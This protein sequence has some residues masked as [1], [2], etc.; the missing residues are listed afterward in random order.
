MT[1]AANCLSDV[2]G[3]IVV[4]K[5]EAEIALVELPIAGLMSDECAE[6][7]I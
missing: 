6:V 1:L 2:G 5:D 7:I 3:G 4:Y